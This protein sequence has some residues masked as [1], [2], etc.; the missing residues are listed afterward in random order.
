MFDR[1]FRASKKNSKKNFH[2]IHLKIQKMKIICF[3]KKHNN[4]FIIPNI[5]NTLIL[6]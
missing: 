4:Y 2:K 6:N 1:D 5:F 3:K